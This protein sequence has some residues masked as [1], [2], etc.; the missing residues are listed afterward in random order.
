[1]LQSRNCRPA[2][3]TA[4]E[5]AS[6][7]PSDVVLMPTVTVTATGA[8]VAIRSQVRSRA[9]TLPD[10]AAKRASN[11]VNGFRAELA[12]LDFPLGAATP[13]VATLAGALDAMRAEITA[14]TGLATYARIMAIA[15]LEQLI[16]ELSSL[17]V[18]VGS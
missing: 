17:G 1:V 8:V 11:A 12:A 18:A 9:A 3:T 15:R 4:C 7:A 2:G 10:P 13:S 5:A 14:Q 6:P 16:A